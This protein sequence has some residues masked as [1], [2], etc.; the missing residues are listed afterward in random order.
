MSSQ[1]KIFA[2]QKIPLFAKKYHLFSQNFKKNS[3]FICI[4]KKKAVPLGDFYNGLI[5]PSRKHIDN[6]DKF[7]YHELICKNKS[8]YTFLASI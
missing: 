2:S 6:T 1:N 8:H 4:Y 3:L 7:R 5:M